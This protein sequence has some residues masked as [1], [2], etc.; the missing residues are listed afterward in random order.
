MGRLE[1]KLMALLILLTGL[2]L[3]VA[4]WRAGALFD[5]SL[6]AGLNPLVASA[7]EDA[8]EVYGAYVHAEKGR[9]RALGEGLAEGQSL[10]AAAAGGQATLE[11]WLATQVA[12]PGVFAVELERAG[13]APLKVG[14]PPTPPEQWLSRTDRF[15]ITDLPGFNGLR[16]TYAT[17]ARRID[18]FRR[19][20]QEVIEPFR[21]LEADR[22]N[23]AGAYAWSF[24]GYLA[25]AIFLA[26]GV[27]V[28]TAR[29]VT[30]RLR[31]LRDGMK[32]VAGGDLAARVVPAG[33]DEV[34][35]LAQGFNE[36]AARLADSQARVQYLNQVSAW[37]GIARK[38]A[39]E[40]K[41]PLTP[42]LLAVQQAHEG[43]RGDDGRHARV[44]ET[45]REI[46]EQEVAV[47]KRL[48][49]NFSRFARLPQVSPS[50]EDAAT[51]VRDVFAAHA[52]LDGMVLVAPEG[53][54]PAALDRD[55]LRQ[56]LTNL[57]NN[58]SEA[59]SEVARPPQIRLAVAPAVGGGARITVDDNG[60]GVPVDQRE[61]I[62]EPYV[63]GK[64]EGTGLGLAIVKKIILDHGGTIA[65][66]E[67]DLGGARF[68]VTLP[69]T[70]A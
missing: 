57:L 51:A 5:R 32:A 38:L 46:V 40:I 22:R 58:A 54:I 52:H 60:P 65:V 25:A 26:A 13:A 33:R 69:G 70:V 67:S 18:A 59:C 50:V 63:T 68:V 47:L 9:F 61:R 7:L 30:R 66:E 64:R 4:L 29:R 15:P 11:V 20:E 62:F 12:R 6:G 39:H 48:V 14:G 31:R 37:Q 45:A 34:A 1:L 44:L 53:T 56:A 2:P 42:I 19:M 16:L 8:V 21:A 55:L 43:Y 10:R 17:E 41:N 3:G 28:V 49:E 23:V 36:M 27:S 35:D 24:V